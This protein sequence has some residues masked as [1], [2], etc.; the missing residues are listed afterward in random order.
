[1]IIK[2]IDILASISIEDILDK[3]KDGQS[4]AD[5]TEDGIAV[6][7][8]DEVS[9]LIDS[10]TKVGELNK[11]NASEIVASVIQAVLF[12]CVFVEKQFRG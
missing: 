1:M 2:G 11:A 9:L 6:R 10:S 8:E 3:V 5:W 4:I 7:C 12:V